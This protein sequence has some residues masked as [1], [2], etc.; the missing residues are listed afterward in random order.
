[1]LNFRIENLYL[2]V[3]LTLGFNRISNRNFFVQVNSVIHSNTYFEKFKI[4][5]THDKIL[6]N[7]R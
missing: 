7:V 5:F 6:T 1:M 2:I 3:F 4:L